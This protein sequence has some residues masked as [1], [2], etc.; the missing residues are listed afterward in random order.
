MYALKGVKIR[1][2]NDFPIQGESPIAGASLYSR[3]QAVPPAFVLLCFRPGTSTRPPNSTLIFRLSFV[4]L[5]RVAG[6][7]KPGVHKT[8][9]FGKGRVLGLRSGGKSWDAEALVCP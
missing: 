3:T 9:V 5:L 8:G 7:L 6:C 2:T 4:A 1:M